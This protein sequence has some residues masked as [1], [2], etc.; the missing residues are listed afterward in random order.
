[1][2]TQSRQLA[3]IMFTDI[4]GYTA[5]MGE[6]EQKAFE[7]LKKNR[8]VQRPIIEKFGGR[9]LKEI[10]DGVMTSFSTVSDAVYCAKEIQ[11]TCQDHPDLNL[12]IGIH[13]GEVV[14]EG[15]DVFGDGVNIASRLESIAPAGGIYISE[16]V[17]RNVENKKNIDADYIGEKELKNVKHPVK[18]FQVIIEGQ[19]T[20]KHAKQSGNQ[21]TG[22][23]KSI[24]VLPFVNMS[25]DPEQEYFSDGLTEEVITDLSQLGSL[26][27]ISRSSMMTFKG[28]A[29]T[30]KQIADE[31]K[32]RYVL[33]G[34]VRK[35]AN[36][37][38]ITAQLIDAQT[39]IHLWAEKYNGSVDDI[40]EIQENVSKSIVA[41]LGIQLAKDK[42]SSLTHHQIQDANTLSYYMNARYE[43]LKLTESG[44]LKAVKIA[45]Q[46]MGVV[47]ENAVLHGTMSLANLY[48]HHYGI[49]VNPDQLEKA[50]SQAN[51]SL[52]LDPKCIQALLVLGIC[53][54]YVE[55]NKLRAA[56]IFKKIL[57]YDKN[58]PDALRWLALSCSTLGYPDVAR[59]M[60]IRL[61][62]LDPMTSET[63]GLRGWVELNA[64][65]I[66]ESIPY[67]E[68]WLQMDP[69]APFNQ[70]WCSVVYAINN[71]LDK[72]IDLLDS[73]IRMFPNLIHAKFAYFFKNAL[74]GQRT[75][76]LRYATQELCHN[77]E[78]LDWLSFG[79]AI[80]YAFLN[81]KEETVKW[82]RILL[83]QDMLMH[84]LYQNIEIFNNLHEHPGFQEFMNDVK[85]RSEAVE[86]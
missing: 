77:A 16:P 68:K 26:L 39:D 8:Q 37:L 79:M 21:R 63:H 76:A 29:M 69:D 10:G 11:I 83:S 4:V 14:F 38:R 58:N 20:N 9:W 54:F 1:M 53:E 43:M 13:Q 59:P 80:G 73:L 28:T 40:F 82:C 45:E 66:K 47:G 78:S 7:L 41:S 31:V 52:S 56:N 55:Y 51:L 23:E 86:I 19:I 75:Y 65:L 35:A 24:A 85:R 71:Q 5:L 33:E 57:E 36:N 22:F 74:K 60:A 72:S 30:I 62:K 61:L 81:E 46:G 49:R 44:L 6:D 42:G 25:S 64:G 27:V 67:H 15:D 84:Q 48:L 2:P 34:S 18:I 12:R 17:F 3:A 70:Y 50:K 32:V